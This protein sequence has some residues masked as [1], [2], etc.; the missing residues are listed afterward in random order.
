MEPQVSPQVN[1]QLLQAIQ[2]ATTA[3]EAQAVHAQIVNAQSVTDI[4]SA[5]TD[6]SDKLSKKPWYKRTEFWI[7]LLGAIGPN[8]VAM[9]AAPQ[10]LVATLPGTVVVAVTYI[11]TNAGISKEQAAGIA[12]VG[13][14]TVTAIATRQGKKV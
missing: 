1:P 5:Q 12:Q 2:S 13:A 9:L 11:L 6:A 7:G 14:A 8:V 4:T 10:L 3:V